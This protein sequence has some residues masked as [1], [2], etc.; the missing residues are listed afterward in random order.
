MTEASKK[1]GINLSKISECCRNNCKSSG[2][3]VWRYAND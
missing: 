2:G 1:T 3:Y